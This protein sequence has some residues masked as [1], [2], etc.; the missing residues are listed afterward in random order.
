MW[1][2]PLLH[3]AQQHQRE[4]QSF[5]RMQRHQGHPAV[6][7]VVVGIAD[8]R[9]VIQKLRQRL[10]ALFRILRGICKFLQV[11]NAREGFR[12]AFLFKRPDIAA[13]ID[14]EADQLRQRG[15][16]AGS[17]KAGCSSSAVWAGDTSS[18][19]SARC[20]TA[21]EQHRKD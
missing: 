15:L 7:L 11:F 20:S 9:S 5:G 4:L 12:R 3:S 17:A 6:R 13:A 10:A 1:K 16:A 19:V 21:L 8:Q 14:D 2:Q 18:A